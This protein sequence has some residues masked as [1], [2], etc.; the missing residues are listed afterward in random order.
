M[1]LSDDVSDCSFVQESFEIIRDE[2]K[3]WEGMSSTG[4]QSSLFK[5]DSNFVADHANDSITDS[6]VLYPSPSSGHMPRAQQI[7]RTIGLII[8]SSE[9]IANEDAFSQAIDAVIYCAK[10]RYELQNEL[11]LAGVCDV[12]V[13][14]FVKCASDLH[15]IIELFKA[16]SSLIQNNND[17]KCTLGQLGLCEYVFESFQEY[18]TNDEFIDI[19]LTLVVDL[20]NSTLGS[21]NDVKMSP[22]KFLLENPSPKK[23]NID[24][25]TNH[26][27]YMVRIPRVD[28]KQAL[29]ELGL[30]RLLVSALNHYLSYN[31]G[32][33]WSRTNSSRIPL[34]S[35]SPKERASNIAAA[36]L[37]VAHIC[38][39]IAFFASNADNARRFQEADIAT[40]LIGVIRLNSDA[41]VQTN[42]EKKVNENIIAALWAI[43][44]LC[45][46]LASNNK[47]RMGEAGMARIL[48]LNISHFKSREMEL[49]KDPNYKK[50]MEYLCWSVLNFIMFSPTNLK[51]IYSASSADLF[52]SIA[53]S[54]RCGAPARVK[55]EEVLKRFR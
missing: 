53:A 1:E 37:Y 42:V 51:S 28:N 49:F 27:K 21:P 14:M 24:V 6:S 11:H 5:K 2:G 30:C 34:P 3:N 45:A 33:P 41:E 20:C 22:S 48:I 54:E 10:S 9:N 13:G 47:V 23:K 40:S 32:Q 17:T 16:F 46:D 12:L 19:A 15:R 4:N 52:A 26:H 25:A 31:A 8:Q 35:S 38:S 43:I 29:G 36:P 18:Y 55:A 7:K 39:T 50:L 44:N